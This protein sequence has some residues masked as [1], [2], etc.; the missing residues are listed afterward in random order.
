MG[1]AIAGHTTVTAGT[2]LHMVSTGGGTTSGSGTDSL[3]GHTTAAAGTYLQKK[4]D[5]PSPIP[6]AAPLPSPSTSVSVHAMHWQNPLIPATIRRPWRVFEEDLEDKVDAAQCQGCRVESIV[7]DR[8]WSVQECGARTAFTNLP[9]DL[10]QTYAEV[11]LLELAAY[12]TWRQMQEIRA[13]SFDNPIQ[14]DSAWE[15]LDCD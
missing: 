7:A 8:I 1:S 6:S 13:S 9:V 15:V 10:Q 11:S 3:A 12:V 14:F 2:T 4:V 5:A